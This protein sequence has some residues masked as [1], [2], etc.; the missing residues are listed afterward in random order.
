MKDTYTMGECV[1]ASNHFNKEN[2]GGFQFYV[3]RMLAPRNAYDLTGSVPSAYFKEPDQNGHKL[4]S[5]CFLVKNL[6]V[7]DPMFGKYNVKMDTYLIDM[8]K[9]VEL[10][11]K[12]HIVLFD[13][14]PLRECHRLNNRSQF[15]EGE[16]N[17]ASFLVDTLR[18]KMFH[19]GC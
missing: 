18:N 2:G 12:Q 11:Q 6:N 1:L 8:C 9:N 13:L 7:F 3:F 15:I 14:Q 17:V 19:A 5:H 10:N 16:W 4:N